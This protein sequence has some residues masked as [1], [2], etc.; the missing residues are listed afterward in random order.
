M[1]SDP[2]RFR[3]RVNTRIFAECGRV[4]KQVTCAECIPE[5]F[6]LYAAFDDRPDQSEWV[7]LPSFE[8][9]GQIDDCPGRCPVSDQCILVQ[10]PGLREW[11][12]GLGFGWKIVIGVEEFAQ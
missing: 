1:V 9:G 12:P 7:D 10:D 11:D 4:L 5:R 8:A 3:E 6:R 2:V